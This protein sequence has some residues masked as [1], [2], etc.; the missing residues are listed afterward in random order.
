[1]ARHWWFP[2]YFP[3]T[4][5]VKM[6]HTSSN[7]W[8]LR[9]RSSLGVRASDCQCTNCNGPVFDPS[10]RR[11]SGIWRAADEAVLNIVRRKTKKSNWQ[12]L[13]AEHLC[14]SR[15]CSKTF[16][17]SITLQNMLLRP[18]SYT[19]KLS[20][21]PIRV[22]ALAFDLYVLYYRIPSNQTFPHH[23]IDE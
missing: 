14:E 9:M 21:M 8:Q 22:V 23:W 13:V 10:I 15:W 7:N 6:L 4:C 2:V 12:K 11:H 17:A 18:L 20:R 19:A 5:E 16:S 3:L 1:M